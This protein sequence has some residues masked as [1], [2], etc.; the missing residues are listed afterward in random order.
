MLL[1]LLLQL[2]TRSA[3]RI[4]TVLTFK[5][6]FLKSITFSISQFI[7]RSGLSNLEVRNLTHDKF[8]SKQFSLNN[9]LMINRNVIRGSNS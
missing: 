8:F 5:H 1:L 9:C 7:E 2:E 6:H 3:V 4:P